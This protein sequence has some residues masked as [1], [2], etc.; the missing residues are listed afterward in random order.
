MKMVKKVLSILLLIFSLSALIE[1]FHIY[2]D[3]Q[4][5]GFDYDNYYE[6]S[7]IQTDGNAY[8]N[9][10]IAA[11]ST[12]VFVGKA[13]LNTNGY[14]FGGN[15]TS[16]YISLMCTSSNMYRV[17]FTGVNNY[18][19]TSDIFNDS[20]TFVLSSSSCEFTDGETSMSLSSFSGSS[21]TTTRNIYIFGR[22]DNGELKS[23]PSGA[24][25]Y[26]LTIQNGNSIARKFYPAERKSDGALGLYDTVSSSFFANSGSGS[27]ISGGRVIYPDPVPDPEND[28]ITV[29][30]LGSGNVSI[31]T[32]SDG[33]LTLTATPSNGFL[34]GSW[35]DGVVSNPRTV[36]A[37][38]SL[39]VNFIDT[40]V[41]YDDILIG[42]YS[43]PIG[44]STY[45]LSTYSNITG[46]ITNNTS[47]TATITLNTSSWY[48]PNHG[49]QV[50]WSDIFVLNDQ[51]IGYVDLTYSYTSSGNTITDIHRIYVNS[52]TFHYNRPV[53]YYDMVIDCDFSHLYRN[54]SSESLIANGTDETVES[55][56]QLNNSSDDMNDSMNDLVSIEDGYNDQFN[57]SLNQIDFT[58]P[59]NNNNLLASANFVI[60]IFNGLISNNFL[61]ILIVIVCILLIGK[62]VIG[63]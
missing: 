63:K 7:Y 46:T 61:S 50:L 28:N 8:I 44:I 2:A 5:D 27:F 54:Q 24:R 43:E 35:S 58:S 41:V 31:V 19:D 22:N 32:N 9:T 30:P 55:S 51:Y 59:T 6:L 17:R 15:N 14:L 36:S 62:K 11:R 38:S 18:Q 12:N 25:I 10:G 49:T 40:S 57:N 26:Y 39:T 56:N 29:S 21:G 53:Y 47:S 52:N 33:T 3:E 16:Y 48:H 42:Y 34:F 4:I 1:P 23:I 37:N 20:F 60:T 45:D 13:L